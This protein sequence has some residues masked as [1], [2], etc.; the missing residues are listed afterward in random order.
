M[1]IF[2]WIPLRMQNV[3]ER[4][5]REIKSCFQKSWRLWDNV[6]R[7]GT[8]RQVTYDNIIR[9]TR[10]ARWITTATDTHSEYVVPFAFPRQRWLR[11]RASLLR[12]MYSACLVMILTEA[13]CCS[14]AEICPRCQT[15]MTHCVS[16]TCILSSWILK[17][18][19]H[20]VVTVL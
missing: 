15:H 19:P 20:T 4:S 17:R 2:H 7:Y 1:V 5:C 9:R 10:C 11:E 14:E 16:N 8:A 6:E 3:S 12:Y 13:N 18:V